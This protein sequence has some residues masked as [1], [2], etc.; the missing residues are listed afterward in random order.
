MI[1]NAKDKEGVNKGGSLKQ[2]S[3]FETKQNLN[4]CVDQLREKLN[5]TLVQCCSQA[6][7][8]QRRRKETRKKKMKQHKRAMKSKSKGEAR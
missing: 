7:R 1:E 6:S 8:S 4:S 5:M 2:K 3:C